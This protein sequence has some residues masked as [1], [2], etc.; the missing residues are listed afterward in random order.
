MG[1]GDGGKGRGGET[2]GSGVATKRKDVTMRATVKF[3]DEQT[4]EIE[5][6]SL[7]DA[8][9]LA[10]S[11][12]VGVDVAHS[13]ARR[14]AGSVKPKRTRKAKGTAPALKADGTPRLKPGRKPKGN[15]QPEPEQAP[16]A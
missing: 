14:S 8:E 15:G 10:L 9:M 13:F 7:E 6:G 2:E 12:I 1:D 4:I 16:A 11:E 3:T 5:I